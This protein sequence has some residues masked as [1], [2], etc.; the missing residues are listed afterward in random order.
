M[1]QI[2]H[3]EKV[4]L[5]FKQEHLSSDSIVATIDEYNDALYLWFGK[6]CSDVRKR[7][8]MRTA[9]SIKKSG[10][11]YGQL[12]IGHDLKDLK[13]VDESNLS[14][15]EVQSNHTELTSIFN[16]KFT[17]KDQFVM[18]I[19]VKPQVAPV[20]Q[21]VEQEVYTEPK[22]EPQ[23]IVP[24]PVAAPNAAPTPEE[25]TPEPVVT[26]APVSRE[27]LP[28][29]IAPELAGQIKLGLLSVVLAQKFSGF[30]LKT[31][32][33]SQGPRYEFLSSGGSLCK[34]TIDGSDLV[35]QPESEFGGRRDEII[36]LLKEK[37][38]SLNI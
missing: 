22:P 24:K 27:E 3:G 16:R 38:S 15:P 19:G 25:V 37:V 6:D 4:P 9:Q 34:V 23:I 12:H 35:I 18:E 32:L 1:L 26:P 7:S 17:M 28:S 2:E 21:P 14:D 10:F 5:P 29:A 33:T 11:A 8:A 30:E 13:V 31:A 36:S 20:P